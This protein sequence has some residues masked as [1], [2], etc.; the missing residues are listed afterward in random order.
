MRKTQWLDTIYRDVRYAVRALGRN[1]GFALTAVL[2]LAL[3]V[4]ANT[5]LFSLVNAVFLKPLPYDRPEEI[6]TLWEADLSNPEG[7]MITPRLP[8][9]TGVNRIMSS[10][11]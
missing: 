3:G 6:V 10:R 1:P 8:S 7:R 2:T 4:G 9:R 5:A 11:T